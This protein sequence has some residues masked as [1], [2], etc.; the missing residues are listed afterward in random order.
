MAGFDSH[1]Y[2]T[3]C[4]DK[5]KGEYPC[6]KKEAI[7][8]YMYCDVLTQDQKRRF[9]TNSYQEKKKKHELKVIQERSSSTLVDPALVTVIGV[10]KGR[11]GSN[12]K[13]S[14]TP[15]AA[16]A[17]KSCSGLEELSSR[18]PEDKKGKTVKKSPAKTTRPTTDSKLKLLG[19][20]WSER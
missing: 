16:K 2:C 19:Q 17:K 4:R 1:T 3:R 9:S 13:V 7:C 14:S 5:G 18:D 8:K 6:V 20:K 11:Q 15:S 10:A 12:Q